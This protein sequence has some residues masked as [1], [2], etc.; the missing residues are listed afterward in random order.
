MRTSLFTE[1]QVIGLLKRAKAGLP[2]TELCREREI[3]QQTFYRGR[4]N[5]GGMEISAA[6]EM[7]RLRDESR[8]L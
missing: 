4:R 3:T 1:A 5:H 7:N 6:Q 8:R 2:V